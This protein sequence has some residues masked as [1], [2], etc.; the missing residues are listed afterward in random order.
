MS[1]T[2]IGFAPWSPTQIAEVIGGLLATLSDN[3]ASPHAQQTTEL[4][5]QSLCSA[6][7][8]ANE[9]AE[10][11]ICAILAEVV[12]A[13]W[14]ASSGAVATWPCWAGLVEASNEVEVG[15]HL[16][17]PHDIQRVVTPAT[18]QYDFHIRIT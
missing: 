6:L 16:F 18:E 13:A 11:S 2:C 4:W 17:K 14:V 8:Q 12:G 1:H 10:G 15:G 5:L 3:L 7:I 9:V